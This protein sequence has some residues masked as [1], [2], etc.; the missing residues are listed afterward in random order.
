M[1]QD[2]ID[3][4]SFKDYLLT[5]ILLSLSFLKHVELVKDLLHVDENETPQSYQNHPSSSLY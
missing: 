5:K 1:L 4:N 2:I 3:A